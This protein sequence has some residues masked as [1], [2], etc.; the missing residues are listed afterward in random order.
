M[1]IFVIGS[2]TMGT[3]IVLSFAQA[4]IEVVMRER[5][6]GKGMKVILNDL[7]RSVQKGKMTEEQKQNILSYIKTTQSLDDAK[8]ADLII[9]AAVETLELKKELF[10]ELDEICKAETIFATNTSSL[11]ITEI[12]NA[13]NRP[14]KVIGMHFFNPVPVMKLVEIIKGIATSNETRDTVVQLYS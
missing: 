3:G 9:E 10:T 6:L 4:N 2:G 7:N 12:A 1:K 11:S 13:T 14:D 8:D 5:T